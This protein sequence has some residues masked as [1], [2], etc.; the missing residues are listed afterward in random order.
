[1]AETQPFQ[2]ELTVWSH[3]IAS[4]PCSNNSRTRTRQPRLESG[5]DAQRNRAVDIY[6]CRAQGASSQ[7]GVLCGPVPATYW[8]HTG[9]GY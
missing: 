9:Y 3:T 1:M 4:V 5:Y 7:R 2:P 8:V 6:I